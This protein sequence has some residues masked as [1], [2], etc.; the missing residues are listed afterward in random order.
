MNIYGDTGN[1]L[2]LLQRMK[3]HGIDA[4][5]TL[6]GVGDALPANADIILGGGAQDAAQSAV[7]RDLA[8][9]ARALRKLADSGVVMLMVCGTYQ[10]FG[11]RFVTADGLDIKGLGIL[12]IETLASSDRMIGNTIYR[13]P[14]GEVVGYENHSGKTTL[15]DPSLALGTVVKGAGNNGRD[16]TEGCVYKNIFGTYSHGPILSK[17]PGLADEIIKRALTRKYGSARLKPLDDATELTA[18]ATAKSRPR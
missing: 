11:R 7:E 5:V 14:W 15:D 17:N 2:V 1:R 9:K 3:W 4:K 8:R 12:P 6:V 18:A 10:L 16:K 13:T